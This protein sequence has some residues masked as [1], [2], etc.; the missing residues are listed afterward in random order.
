M[1]H[2]FRSAVFRDGMGGDWVLLGATSINVELGCF[3]IGNKVQRKVTDRE[4]TGYAPLGSK[5]RNVTS[6]GV[7]EEFP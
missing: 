1:L 5:L 6:S 7:K 4:T 3:G 2:I